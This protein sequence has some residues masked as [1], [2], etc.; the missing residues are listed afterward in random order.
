MKRTFVLFLSLLM[1][2]S[3]GLCSIALAEADY[4][5]YSYDELIDIQEKLK[6]EIQTRPEAGKGTLETGVYIVGK[7]IAQGEYVLRPLSPESEYA[8]VA[9]YE[10]ERIRNTTST[11]GSWGATMM[12]DYV[13]QSSSYLRLALYEGNVVESTRT[14]VEIERVGNVDEKPVPPEYAV[15]D[16]TLIPKGEYTVGDLIPA[17]AYAI[18]YNGEMSA[19]VRMYESSED[20]RINWGAKLRKT[21]DIYDP[22]V[23]ATLPEGFVLKIDYGSVIMKKAG[24]FTFE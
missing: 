21:L 8:Q 9:T 16:G 7:D 5:G 15:P 11:S 20:A 22:I 14:A 12:L 1:L 19:L 4:S 24:A 23:L 6:L 3:T 13:S 18:H 10:N 2:I 17:G